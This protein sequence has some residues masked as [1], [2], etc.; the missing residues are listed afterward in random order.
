[1]LCTLFIEQILLRNDLVRL[2]ILKCSAVWHGGGAASVVVLIMI[3]VYFDQQMGALHIVGLMKSSSAFNVFDLFH[4][5][6]KKEKAQKIK[7]NTH[8][9]GV[10]Q[11]L[12]ATLNPSWHS[13]SKN[14]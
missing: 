4:Y 8:K 6:Q 11:H 2:H 12:G 5:K 7:K 1:M 10:H 14:F 9:T 13:N 3:V